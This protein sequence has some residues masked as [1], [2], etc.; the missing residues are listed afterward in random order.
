MTKAGRA[1]GGG[2]IRPLPRLEIGGGNSGAVP[3]RD[4]PLAIG[5]HPIGFERGH[6]IF[7]RSLRNDRYLSCPI[8]T[9]PSTKPAK[10]TKTPKLRM[11]KRPS[12]TWKCLP[13]IRHRRQV[14][15]EEAT[16]RGRDRRLA[17]AARRRSAAGRGLVPGGRG[18]RRHARPRSGPGFLP[19]A[20]VLGRKHGR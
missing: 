12:N 7:H 2:D 17:A 8:S 18:K 6:R 11:F 5:S 1:G 13:R 16:V 15:E 4:S 9:N 10:Q 3:E 19:L 14:R 20:L